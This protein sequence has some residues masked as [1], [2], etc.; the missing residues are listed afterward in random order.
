[1]FTTIANQTNNSSLEEEKKKKNTKNIS[2]IKHSTR[3]NTQFDTQ[4]NLNSLQSTIIWSPRSS[5]LVPS[6][7]KK[8]GI[9]IH[10][11]LKF[12]SQIFLA[13]KHNP[14]STVA[15]TPKP[16]TY[17][18]QHPKCNH[19]ITNYLQHIAHSNSSSNFPL[20][21]ASTNQIHAM[22]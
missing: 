13:T 12:S 15:N 8:K 19:F 20:I 17:L 7:H 21:S 5:I 6:P 18:N 16:Q 2:P 14:K 9:L 11:S 1:M 4:I 10:K 3:T 22:Q